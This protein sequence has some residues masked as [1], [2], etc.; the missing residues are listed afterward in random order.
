MKQPD[1]SRYRGSGQG[2]FRRLNLVKDINEL[3]AG[4][5]IICVSHSFQAVNVARIA[6][7]GVTPDTRLAIFVDP[8]DPGRKRDPADGEFCIH[9]FDLGFEWNAYYH[10]RQPT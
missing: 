10:T 2:R 7:P 8:A 4:D 3:I 9:A 5:L 6:G 1:E